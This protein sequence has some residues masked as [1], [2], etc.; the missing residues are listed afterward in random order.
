MK[1]MPWIY[2]ALGVVFMLGLMGAQPADAC[3]ITFEPVSG[4]ADTSGIAADTSGVVELTAIVK[5]EHRRCVLDEDDFNVDY[6]GMVELS[7]TGW[8]RVKR[9]LYANIFKVK[10]TE[11]DGTMRVWRDCS[12]KGVSEGM[13]RLYRP[14]Q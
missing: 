14:E 12:K 9:G 2:G 1:R 7:N 8:T 4:E 13:V 3:I 6:K 5:W 10:L 11:Q